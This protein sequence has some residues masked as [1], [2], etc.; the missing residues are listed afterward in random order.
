MNN[1]C[2]LFI[3][4][5]LAILSSCDVIKQTGSALLGSQKQLTTTEVAEGLKS[6]LMVGTDSAISRLNQVD[7]YFLD[8]NI[9]INLPPETDYIIG[10]ARKVPGLDK[11]I[12]EVI[13]KINRSAEDAAAKATPIFKE[14]IRSMNIED[15][16]GI[17]NGADSSATAYLKAKTYNSLYELYLPVMQESLNKPILSNISAQKSWDEMT[18]LWNRFATSFA[19]KL[20]ELKTIDPQ[21]DAYVTR[22]AMDGVFQKI[23]VQEKQIRFNA[24]ARVNELLKRVFEKRE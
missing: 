2:I 17:L 14:A 8:P 24:D 1:K 11:H 7:G 9:K 4:L 19:G 20:L 18:T 23:A 5:S 12:D 3:F 6:A 10:Y 16:W 13:L 15:A 22:K 21:L